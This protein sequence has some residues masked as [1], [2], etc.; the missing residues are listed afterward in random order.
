M[1][2]VRV[3]AAVILI[4][5]P[6]FLSAATD[7]PAWTGDAHGH[8]I[9]F[10]ASS[11]ELMIQSYEVASAPAHEVKV[12]LPGELFAT[13]VV[14]SSVSREHARRDSPQAAL[15]SDYSAQLAGDVD[16]ILAS[17]AAADQTDMRKMLTDPEMKKANQ[18][19]LQQKG[20]PAVV[21]WVRLK[22]AVILLVQ[23]RDGTRMPWVFVQEDGQ[24]KQT[25]ALSSDSTLDVVFA[26]V[27]EGSFR[28]RGGSP[29]QQP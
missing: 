10:S 3:W 4:G 6:R 5:C 21:G 16:W 26:A 2:H 18:D 20:P 14:V 1:K 23:Y 12:A 29:S 9:E 19:M 13:P 11:H 8:T 27:R 28:E 24:W 7:T 17:F 22:N 15:Q 25:N